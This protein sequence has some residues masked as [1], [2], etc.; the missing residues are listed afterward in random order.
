MANHFL[1]EVLLQQLWAKCLNTFPLQGTSLYYNA[2]TTYTEG[3]VVVY[4]HK[5][6]ICKATT[7]G[8]LPTNTT[9]WQEA[10]Q[11]FIIDDIR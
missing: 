8:N 11:S 6:Y 3:N 7:T 2:S 9:Y 1:D 5:M 10:A 4:N